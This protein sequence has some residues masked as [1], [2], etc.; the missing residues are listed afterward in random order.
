MLQAITH[1]RIKKSQRLRVVRYFGRELISVFCTKG[2]VDD[3]LDFKTAGAVHLALEA[4]L[5]EPC[6]GI[7]G[8]FN[9]ATIQ[10]D[11]I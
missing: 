9:G 1:N 4:I 2:N 11:L 10:V 5:Q 7:S 8:R 6:R 3:V